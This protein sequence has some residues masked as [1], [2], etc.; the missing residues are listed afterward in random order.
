M[1]R[2]ALLRL[3]ARRDYRALAWVTYTDPELAHVGLT[4]QQARERYGSS[5]RVVGASFADNDRARAEGRTSGGIKVI[6]ERRGRILG[7]DILGAHA[8]ELVALWGLAIT[9]GLK[10]GAL[11][12][13][14]FPYPTLAE[15]SKAS[16]AAFYAPKLFSPWPRRLVRLLLKWT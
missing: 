4:E 5:V 2:N 1:I 9:R 3:G 8:G 10:L 16:A 11:T 6:V 15:V 12:G 14:M 13:V 7:A